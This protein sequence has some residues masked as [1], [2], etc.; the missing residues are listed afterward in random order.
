[1]SESRDE[2][3]KALVDLEIQA[4][5]LV[6]ENREAGGLFVWAQQNRLGLLWTHGV[7][8]VVIGLLMLFTGA[9]YNVEATLGLWT[10]TAFAAGGMFGGVLLICGLTRRPRSIPAEAAGL[11]VLMLWDLAIAVSFIFVLA[12]NPPSFAW[13]W[14]HIPQESARPYPVAVYGVLFV[15]LGV[16]AWTLAGLFKLGRTT[17]R[18]AA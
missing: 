4:D 5:Q 13:P 2:L 14:Q 12:D 10:R 7:G 11:I 16:H 6:Q 15:L 3:V 8:A 9:A 1:M 18:G 17:Q